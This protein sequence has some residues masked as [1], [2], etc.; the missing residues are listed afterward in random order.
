[1]TLRP[2]RPFAERSRPLD[3][4][5][6]SVRAG[7]PNTWHERA[8]R[9]GSQPMSDGSHVLIE[10][11]AVTMD[12]NDRAPQ[13]RKNMVA[14][15]LLVVIVLASTLLFSNFIRSAAV[16]KC[17]TSGRQDCAERVSASPSH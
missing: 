17:V 15:A 10:C 12:D 4:C 7:A 13:T 9:V 1:M 2:W 8:K 3:N 14:L 11:Y 5:G 6:F 16:L